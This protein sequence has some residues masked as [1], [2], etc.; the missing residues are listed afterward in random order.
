M[1]DHSK[2]ILIEMNGERKMKKGW[3]VLFAMFWVEM[4]FVLA[5]EAQNARNMPLKLTTTYEFPSDVK[6]NFDHITVDVR[7]HRLFATPEDHQ[8][9]EI[10]DIQTGKLIHRITGIGRPHSV[11]YREDLDRFYV[12]DGGAGELKIFD[13]KSYHLIKSVKLLVDADPIVYDPATKYLYVANGGGEAKMTYSTV[14][15]VDTT[16]GETIGDM[17]IDGETLEGMVLESS[18]PRMYVNNRDKNQVEVIDR[19]KRT[20][21]VSWPVT[22]GKTND[23]IALDEADHRLFVACRSGHIVVFDTASGKELQALPIGAGVDDLVFDPESKRIYAPCGGTG[24]VDVYEQIDP[25]HYKLLGRIPSGAL[26]KT[27]RLVPQLHRYFVAVP[28]HGKQNAEILVYQV[29]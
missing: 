14:S 23:P 27:G 5:V 8:S 6:G 3:A 19:N 29:Q 22:L 24:T 28:Q 2:T 20:V 9:I 25:D 17:K 21:L 13:G 7:E 12:T 1:R 26:A 10:F 4:F 15:I 16:R 18:S 11:L